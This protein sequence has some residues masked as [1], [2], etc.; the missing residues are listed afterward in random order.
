MGGGDIYAADI[1]G[2]CTCC[3]QRQSWSKNSS[4]FPPYRTATAEGGAD[5]VA[6]RESVMGGPPGHARLLGRGTPGQ[7]VELYGARAASSLREQTNY[8][9]IPWNPVPSN[10]LPSMHAVRFLSIPDSYIDHAFLLPH[11]PL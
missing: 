10:R 7:S 3:G 9:R 8:F 11:E 4:G 5:G 2:Y 1:D 6:G